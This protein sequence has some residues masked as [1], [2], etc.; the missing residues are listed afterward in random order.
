MST[1]L[2]WMFYFLFMFF[3]GLVGYRVA[4]STKQTFTGLTEHASLINFSAMIAIGILFGIVLAPPFAYLFQKIIDKIVNSLQKISLQEIILGGIGLSFGLLLALLTSLPIAA[5]PINEIPVFGVYIESFLIIFI[6]IFWSYLGIYFATRTA[7]VHDMG[8]LFTKKSLKGWGKNY[9]I[10][11]SSVIIDGRIL[12]IIRSGFVEGNLLVPTFI[13]NEVQQL[14]DSA[15]YLRR[16]RGRRG[17]DMLHQLRKEFAV[18]VS[19]KDYSEGETDSKLV[20]FAIEMKAD[21]LTTDFNLNKVAQ[22]QGVRVLNINELAQAIKPVVLPGEDMVVHIVKEGKESNQ[23]VGYLD[24]GTMVVVE[25][26]R[27]LI[28]ETLKVEVTSV[29][30]TMAGKMI[31]ARPQ[32][33]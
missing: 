10:L 9:K 31:F 5:L 30:Q 18:Q 26:G 21:L 23:G 22:L 33:I 7:V 20:K 13:L 6:A 32:E 19:D 2:R 15:D 24:D 3:G 4:Q 27:K 29:I 28:G 1:A 12:D 8:Q 14:A 11:D 25:N 16:N 17:L